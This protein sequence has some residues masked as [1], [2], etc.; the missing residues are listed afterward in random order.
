VSSGKD[1]CPVL[2]IPT[3]ATTIDEGKNNDVFDVQ[4]LNANFCKTATQH[5]ATKSF[6][7]VHAQLQS[8]Y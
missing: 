6:V 7:L 1:F 8:I 3:H 5:I 2:L 4:F